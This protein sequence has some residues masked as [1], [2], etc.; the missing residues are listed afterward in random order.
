[1]ASQIIP[2]PVSNNKVVGVKFLLDPSRQR[3]WRNDVGC[4]KS[5]DGDFI[6]GLLKKSNVPFDGPSQYGALQ[7]CERVQPSLP[8][9]EKPF[10]FSAIVD[11]LPNQVA[12]LCQ[13]HDEGRNK[14]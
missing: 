4:Q 13:E 8:F 9:L 7:R 6:R 12:N 2:S 11:G 3:R 1:M 10:R 14:P 5:D